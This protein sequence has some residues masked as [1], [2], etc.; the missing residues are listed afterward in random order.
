MLLPVTRDRH[1]VAI[2]SRKPLAGVILSGARVLLLILTGN[3]N[4]PIGVGLV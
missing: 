2:S 4:L 1:S 3:A